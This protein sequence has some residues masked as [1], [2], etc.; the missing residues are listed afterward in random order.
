MWKDR[1]C[2]E[3]KRRSGD[4]VP[5]PLYGIKIVESIA[6]SIVRLICIPVAIQGYSQAFRA[7]PEERERPCFTDVSHLRIVSFPESQQHT[8]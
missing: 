3:H 2:G 8:R 1:I 4:R 7:G 6:Q 5:S